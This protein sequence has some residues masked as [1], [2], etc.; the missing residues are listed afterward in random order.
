[1]IRGWQHTT[2]YSILLLNNLSKPSS[3]SLPSSSQIR[4]NKCCHHTNI[5]TCTSILN[6]LHRTSI[7]PTKS[8]ID[9]PEDTHSHI[10]KTTSPNR[11]NS[12]EKTYLINPTSSFQYLRCYG[13]GQ[14]KY[15]GKLVLSICFL[16]LTPCIALS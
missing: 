16:V 2:L 14:Q 8:A 5:P 7:H 1:V 10:L 6:P 15:F 4:S 11:K 12:K 9:S 13:T 3:W